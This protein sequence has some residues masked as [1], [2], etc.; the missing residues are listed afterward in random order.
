MDSLEKLGM[1]VRKHYPELDGYRIDFNYRFLRNAAAIYHYT[2]YVIDPLQVKIS[3][4]IKNRSRKSKRG[5]IA[6]ELA[7][8]YLDLKNMRRPGGLSAE[9]ARY[10]RSKSYRIKSEIEADT[11]AVV[12][13]FGPDLLEF[14]KTRDEDAIDS[15]GGLTVEEIRLLMKNLGYLI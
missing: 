2:K 1:E 5:I 6:H 7:H 12:R 15:H 9:V 4:D 3:Y 13:G 10:N 11:V 8:I 14:V